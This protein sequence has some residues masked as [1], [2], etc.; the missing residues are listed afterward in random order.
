[1][2]RRLFALALCLGLLALLLPSPARADAVTDTIG[3]YV[4]YY[5]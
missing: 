2:K 1:M 4:G 5:G 3:I